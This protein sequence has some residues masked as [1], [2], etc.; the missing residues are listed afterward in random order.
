MPNHLIPKPKM[1][2][3]TTLSDAHSELMHG[4]KRQKSK[5][6]YCKPKRKCGWGN[7]GSSH[8]TSTAV[9]AGQTSNNLALTLGHG[10][11]TN[12]VTQTMTIMVS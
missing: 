3:L 10:T 1:L 5:S 11:A 7:Q 12:T 2:K 8:H 6:Y 9:M 4:G